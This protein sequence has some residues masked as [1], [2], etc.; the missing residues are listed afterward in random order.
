MSTSTIETQPDK[1]HS[2]TRPP[3]NHSNDSE[4]QNKTHYERAPQPE[5]LNSPLGQR[6]AKWPLI[7]KG[8]IGLLILT[9]VAVSVLGVWRYQTRY[10]NDDP[11]IVTNLKEYT[12][13]DYPADPAP[14]SKFYKRYTNRQ[15]VVESTGNNLFNF[16]LEPGDADTAKIVFKDIDLSLFVPTAPQY[17]RD[18]AGLR[19]I[20]LVDRE[21][22]RQQ[23][24][25]L[26]NSPHIEISGGDGV[27]SGNIMQLALARNCL[28]AGLWEVILTMKENGQ[29]KMYYQ[30]WFDFPMAH[31]KAV[32][33]KQ[34]G[35]SWWQNWHRLDHWFDPEGT[36]MEMDALRRVVAQEV[37]PAKFLADE[38]VLTSG[39]QARK[40]RTANTRDVRTWGDFFDPKI[41]DSISFSTFLP[42][43][44][45]RHETPW[46]NQYWRLAQFNG[47]L[48]RH[49]DSPAEPGKPLQEIEL[50]F[51]DGKNGEKNRLLIGGLD[52]YALPQLPHSDFNKGLYHPMGIGVGPFYQAYSDLKKAPPYLSAYYS[53][54]LNQKNEWLDHHSIAVDGPVMYRDQNDPNLVHLYLLSYERHS[55][56]AHFEITLPTPKT[57]SLKM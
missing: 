9:L 53:F 45:Y 37:I 7:L 32:F 24:S 50:T 55:L 51:T 12:T 25:F 23:V 39:E 48:L 52:F 46:E 33:E 36:E 1:G 15:L 54:L 47:A 5:I 21:W 28:N 57:A 11:R 6:K 16:V 2:P 4:R 19:K 41:S 35:F 20:A 38:P 43:G 3:R 42:P 17:T 44:Q 31:Y 22:N 27:E 56:I 10:S 26:P 34:N 13:H 49:I 40:I 8:L 18:H 14:L 29:K 30:G